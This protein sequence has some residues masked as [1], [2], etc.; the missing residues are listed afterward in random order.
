[1]TLPR[2]APLVL[3]ASALSGCGQ[4]GPL[5]LEGPTSAAQDLQVSESQTD[6]EQQGDQE[7]ES[8]GDG[9]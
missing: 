8:S 4:K 3:L 9:R 7:E 5:T 6:E 2:F 1:M